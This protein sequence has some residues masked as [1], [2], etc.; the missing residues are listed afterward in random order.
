MRA[1]G[2]AWRAVERFL[3][4]PARAAPLAALRIGLASVLLVQALQVAPIFRELHHHR[5]LL[6]GPLMDL[7]APTHL[8]APGRLLPALE[9]HGLPESLVLSVGGGLYL[10]S[11]VGL[12]LGWRTRVAAVAA[13]L[14]H[15]GFMLLAPHTSYGADSFANIFLFYSMFAPVGAIWSI[16][17]RQGRGSPAPDAAKRL[18][19]RV[20]Q[21]QLCIAYLSSGLRK[22]S[23]AQWYD[24]E[25]I[26]RSLMAQGYQWAD[27][28]WLARYPAIA[29]VA[30]WMVLVVEVG[31]PL[32]IWPRRTRRLW[33]A[34]V[35]GMHAGIAVFMGLH[36]FGALM[37]VLSVALFG[38]EAEPVGAGNQ[39]GVCGGQ[40]G[41]CGGQAGA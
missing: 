40:A 3:F 39:A 30:G 35:V 27:F 8:P 41:V 6:R 29:V 10:A 15:V 17:H 13:W 24:G 25:A 23:G 19:L 21:I 33:I 4:A 18:A 14:L 28:T 7:F 36:V 20:M 16:D 26:W 9:A 32:F 22:A 1:A 11:L 12:L 37:I 31:Y 2:R 34:A 5:G 38:V